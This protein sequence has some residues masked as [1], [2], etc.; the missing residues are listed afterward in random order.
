MKEKHSVECFGLFRTTLFY[1]NIQNYKNITCSSFVN[2]NIVLNLHFYEENQSFILEFIKNSS[3][4]T[5]R[6]TKTLS[7]VKIAVGH[8]IFPTD[9]LKSLISCVDK[10]SKMF[11]S[12]KKDNK[13]P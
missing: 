8:R 1:I 11:D 4:C 2:V 12:K 5:S 6:T 3:T 7:G 10:L 9:L 13:N